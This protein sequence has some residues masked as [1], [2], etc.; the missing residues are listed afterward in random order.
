[1]EKYISD[2][3]TKKSNENEDINGINPPIYLLSCIKD[4]SLSNIRKYSQT[5]YCVQCHSGTIRSFVECKIQK[6]KEYLF[7]IKFLF[8][9]LIAHL[10]PFLNQCW[11]KKTGDNNNHQQ[12]EDL[13][14]GVKSYFK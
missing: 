8:L 6:R 5:E 12:N 11:I 1:M 2:I 10:L 7:L 9:F 3:L 13:L 4:Q 14:E